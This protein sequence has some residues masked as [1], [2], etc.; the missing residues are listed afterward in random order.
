MDPW[1]FGADPD[2]QILTTDLRIRILPFSSVASKMPQQK[3]SF[4]STFFCL[5]FW[6][7]IS[8]KLQRLKVKNKSQTVESKVF[9]TFLLDDRRIRI[10]ICTNNDGSG[11][12]RPKNLRI[13][14]HNTV[15][16][17][18]KVNGSNKLYKTGLV[19]QGQQGSA[20][21]NPFSLPSLFQLPYYSAY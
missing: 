10:R 19:A 21:L 17:F 6:N 8:I 16:V 1:H 2:P 9:L 15:F 11:S 3:I 13:R 7:Y 18:L 5:L 20:A 14:F 4:F 12:G